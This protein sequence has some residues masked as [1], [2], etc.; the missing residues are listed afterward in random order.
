MKFLGSLSLFA[1][2]V[3]ASGV[4][5]TAPQDQV[6]I[7]TVLKDIS[8]YVDRLA[9]SVG[10]F[11]GEI[12]PLNVVSGQVLKAINDGI[13]KIKPSSKLSE[14]EAINIA[15]SVQGLNGS[16]SKVVNDIIAKK[17]VFLQFNATADVLK[18]LQDQN[19]A[20]KMLADTI[21][22]KVPPNLQ[23]LAAQLSADINKTLE[24]G[25]AAFQTG[26]PPKGTSTG[27]MV[28]PPKTTSSGSAVPPP[29]STGAPPKTTG[30]PSGVRPPV[31]S[32][33]AGSVF[34]AP[35]SM[36]LFLLAAFTWIGM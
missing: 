34:T 36:G 5:T 12:K 27:T 8:M 35:E 26:P 3:T 21:T 10:A 9:V 22:T 18:S 30:A 25:I 31:V 14:T 6:L 1:V 4:N 17:P 24:K 19:K 33:G 7:Q 11:K 16:V 29:K 28:P 2:V 32:T 20:A 13:D 15:T 23:A